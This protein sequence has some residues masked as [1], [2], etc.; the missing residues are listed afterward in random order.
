MSLRTA[1]TSRMTEASLGKMPTTRARRLISR[2][3]RSIGF[4]DQILVQWLRGKP[5][6]ASSSAF[7]VSINGP[8][9][10]EAAG[11]LVTDFVPGL[12]R[13]SG[14]GWA[15]AVRNTAGTRSLCD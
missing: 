2:L 15:N 12:E 9:L 5:V 7:A 11:E 3:I 13:G 8:D 14:V 1:A 10:G 4:V 6:N